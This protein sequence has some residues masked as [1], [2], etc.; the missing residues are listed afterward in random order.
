MGIIRVVIFRVGI[1]L[2]GSY[3]GG[4]FP[5]WQ[6]PG[7]ECSGWKFSWVAIFQMGLILGGNF[8]WWKFSRWELSGGKHA[9]GNFPGGSLHV[10]DSVIVTNILVSKVRFTVVPEIL[11]VAS[12]RTF[13]F[14]ICFVK[15]IIQF[16]DFISLN[17]IEP[18]IFF[19]T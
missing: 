15:F 2:G 9:G 11:Y 6:L 3:L 7:W 13:F 18:F 5:G 4:S 10:T 12:F 19:F 14:K 16:T 8:L 17:V 1:F